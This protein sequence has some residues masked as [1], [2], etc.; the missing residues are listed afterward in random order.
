MPSTTELGDAINRSSRK[1]QS[2][3]PL[4][5]ITRAIPSS[6]LGDS[7]QSIRA[8]QK[9][10]SCGIGGKIHEDGAAG[11]CRSLGAELHGSGKNGSIGRWSEVVVL[12]SSQSSWNWKE[13]SSR[14]L[15]WRSEQSQSDGPSVHP[16]RWAQ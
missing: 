4:V 16:D 2:T 11:Y 8:W 13:F 14:G 1:K 10:G 5:L 6:R 12:S 15:Q 7:E 3:P 9:D